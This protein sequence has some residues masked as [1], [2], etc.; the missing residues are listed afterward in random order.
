M[1]D[2]TTLT[3]SAIASTQPQA[4]VQLFAAP[5]MLQRKKQFVSTTSSRSEF[6]NQFQQLAPK[7][8]RH[9]QLERVQ[10][11]VHNQFYDNLTSDSLLIQMDYAEN[12]KLV[13][14]EQRY[15]V[16]QFPFL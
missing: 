15:N 7:A 10:R 5:K 11:E 2:Y 8:F 9:H 6:L 13:V 1:V 16:K 14:R 4:L 3:R 12:I